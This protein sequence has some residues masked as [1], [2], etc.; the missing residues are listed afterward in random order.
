VGKAV[1][2]CICADRGIGRQVIK[3]REFD[4]RV[5]KGNLDDGVAAEGETTIRRR[6]K[7]ERY[8]VCRAWG[9]GP[10]PSGKREH[11]KLFREVRGK[12]GQPNGS[13]RTKVFSFVRRATSI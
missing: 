11:Q 9:T 13:A 7:E 5:V 3:K 1:F 6:Q 10:S 4:E 2:S 12:G 8:K